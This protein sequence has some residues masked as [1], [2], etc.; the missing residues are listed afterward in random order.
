MLNSVSTGLELNK[1]EPKIIPLKRILVS[2]VDRTGNES[3]KKEIY[4]LK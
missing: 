2:G 1:N 3:D 4:L